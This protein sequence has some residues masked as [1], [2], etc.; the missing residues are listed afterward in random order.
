MKSDDVFPA[1]PVA[2]TSGVAFLGSRRAIAH[3][4]L[5]VAAAT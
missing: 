1:V 2:V 4:V 5:A 3:G